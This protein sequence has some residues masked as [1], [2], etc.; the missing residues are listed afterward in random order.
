MKASAAALVA[1]LAAASSSGVVLVSSWSSN[2][3]LMTLV[4]ISCS[5]GSC[6]LVQSCSGILLVLELVLDYL[7]LVATA[8]ALNPVGVLVIGCWFATA[9]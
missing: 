8:G 6:F 4:F 1:V 5:V 9:T 7:G 3:Y 2:L